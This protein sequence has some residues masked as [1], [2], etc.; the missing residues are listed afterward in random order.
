MGRKPT[1]EV[2]IDEQF[3]LL[4]VL[5]VGHF[6]GKR[7]ARV[8]CTGHP[9]DPVEKWVQLSAL[10]SG[11]VKSCGC[12]SRATASRRMHERN[13]A[14]PPR[15]GTGQK[16]LPPLVK[17]I[18]KG[19]KWRQDD[20]GRECAYEGE[21]NCEHA[22]KAWSEFNRGNGARGHSSWCR[23]CQAAHASGKPPRREYSLAYRCS[24]FG[25]TVE[26]YRAMEA[27]HGGRC[28]L[29]LEFEAITCHDGSTRRLVID[30]DHSCC[31]F[32]PTPQHPLCGK[33]IRGLCCQ[34]CNRRVLGNVDAVGPDKVF[35]YL[36]SAQD[37]AQALLAWKQ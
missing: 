32:D 31:G 29:C 15:L 19:P 33:C 12:L 13:L 11:A 27:V 10:T 25:I 6:Q 24:A 18:P 22:F 26:Q 16:G 34:R 3:D 8:R 20:S 4:V 28:W 17:Y 21:G 30:H 35:R 23:S 7:A 1:V 9:E 2:A 5:E 36:A 37:A 14:A